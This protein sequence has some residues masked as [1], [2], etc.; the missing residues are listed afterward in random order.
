VVKLLWQISCVQSRQHRHALHLCSGL[1][2]RW[3]ANSHLASWLRPQSHS[4]S[5]QQQA[6]ACFLRSVGRCR[7]T[8]HV[9]AIQSFNFQCNQNTGCHHTAHHGDQVVQ[10]LGGTA[11][12]GPMVA[13]LT[14]AQLAAN[15]L[16]VACPCALGLAA[17][18]AVLVGTS[19]GKAAKRRSCRHLSSCM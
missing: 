15:V 2:T 4:S 11:A 19:A 6:C 17:P 13:L 18:T 9:A 10:R 7:G 8:G 16:V 3:Q 5:G 12:S 14:G 1:Q